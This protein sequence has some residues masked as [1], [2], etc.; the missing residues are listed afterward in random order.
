MSLYVI[1]TDILTL[2]QNGQPTV[3]Q[4][5]AAHQPSELAITVITVEEQTLGRLT[6]IRRARQPD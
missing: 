3:C 1:D 5:V 6:Q 2:Y 4:H